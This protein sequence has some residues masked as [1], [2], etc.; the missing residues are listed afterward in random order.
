MQRHALG[1]DLEGR[2]QRVRSEPWVW[3]D[4]NAAI[5]PY[6][7]MRWKGGTLYAGPAD[8]AFGFPP[9]LIQGSTLM[10]CPRAEALR[11]A[12]DSKVEA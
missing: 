10:V 5:P 8:T 11:M 3:A 12:I 2:M 4:P 6:A 9:A 1:Y 7:V